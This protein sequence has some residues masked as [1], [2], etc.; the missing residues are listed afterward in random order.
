MRSPS[1]VAPSARRCSSRS[2]CS[3]ADETVR[4]L[5]AAVARLGRDSGG[6]M[7]PR[8][9]G[10]DTRW[11]RSG[12][13]RGGRRR[14]DLVD[15]D[16]GNRRPTLRRRWKIVRRCVLASPRRRLLRG[17]ARTRC[18]RPARAIRLVRSTPSSCWVRPSTTAA[19]RRSSRPGSTTSSPCGRRV[20]AAR[21]RHRRQAAGDRFTEAEASARTSWSAACPRR[22]SSWRRRPATF[23]SLAGAADLL[24]RAWSRH[25][26]RRHRP[27]PRIADAPDRRGRRADGVR[28]ADADEV[29]RGASRVRRHLNEAGGVALG[30]I[31]GFDRL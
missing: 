4:R 1:P 3:A 12:R 26:A 21:R 15:F 10:D 7:I 28:V 18:G 13:S 31:I 8:A 25:R 11:R 9:R 2:R 24:R 23:E 27:V 16:G 30:R 22:R 14:R 6:A 29:V 17:H 19:R 20:R 5:R